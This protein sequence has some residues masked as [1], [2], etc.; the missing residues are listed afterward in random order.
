[1]TALDEIDDHIKS[2]KQE[3]IRLNDRIVVLM[4]AKEILAQSEQNQTVDNH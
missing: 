3:I 4:K 2:A 1:M